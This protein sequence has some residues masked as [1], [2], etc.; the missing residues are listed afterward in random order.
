[1][2]LLIVLA[3]LASLAAL[4]W[5]SIR[6]MLA[7]SELQNAA[8]QFRAALVKVRLDAIQSGTVRQLRY[9][10]GTGRFEVSVLAAIDSGLAGNELGLAAA[11]PA[12]RPAEDRLAAGVSF[13]DPKEP[14][15][16]DRLPAD[17]LADSAELLP[18]QWSA[19]ILFYPNG[20]TSDAR[21]RLKGRRGYRMEVTLRGVTGAVSVGK[22]DWTEAP[23]WW[24]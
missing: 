12:N 16:A 22:L 7:K 19:P 8:R 5:P 4:S 21:V 3:V 9:R 15:P 20:R 2:E 13:H 18:D 11:D 24:P 6:E 17:R 1:V 23:E 10:P 14:Q